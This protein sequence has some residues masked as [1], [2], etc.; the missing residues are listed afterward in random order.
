VL[1]VVVVL[2]AVACGGNGLDHPDA[3]EAA[4]QF[5]RHTSDGQWGRSWDN[6]HPAH[7]EIV[8]RDDYIT[9]AQRNESYDIDGVRAVETFEEPVGLP[10]TSITTDSVA[11]TVEIKA[12]EVT[13]RRTSHFVE[14]DGRWAWIL[15]DPGAYADEGCP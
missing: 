8:D 12:G 13:D 15:N 14:I 7:Q 11:V 5:Y 2:L 1:T 9:C 3:A 10:G 6:L 4:E